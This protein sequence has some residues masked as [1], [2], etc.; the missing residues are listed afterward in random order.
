MLQ[1]TTTLPANLAPALSTLS[2]ASEDG[3]NTPRDGGT[4]ESA[5][6]ALV[7]QV[8]NYFPA[9]LL[10]RAQ[11]ICWRREVRR[12]RPTKIPYSPIHLRGASSTAPDTWGEFS[13]AAAFYLLRQELDG[14]GFVF[15]AGD[16]YWG[17]DLDKCIDLETGEIAAWALGIVERLGSYT[18]FSPSRAGLHIIG[19]G[20][21]PGAGLKRGSVELYDRARYFTVTG[22]PFPGSTGSPEDRQAEVAEL[23]AALDVETAKPRRRR[24]ASPQPPG[25]AAAQ[26]APVG[27][28]AALEAALASPQRMKFVQLWNGRWPEA[29]YSSQSEADLALV[30]ILARSTG[31]NPEQIDRL[32]RASGLYREKWDE[33]RGERTY[34]QQTIMKALGER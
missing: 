26:G 7:A 32:F 12:G 34:G 15:S 23:Y 33:R 9:E 29:R 28:T 11:W 3:T 31:G 6:M 27:D 30:S 17:V 13:K 20:T 16:P 5:R 25:F 8:A 14:L 2:A 21:L 19:R 22:E 24:W 18:E 1:N 10:Q 4:P